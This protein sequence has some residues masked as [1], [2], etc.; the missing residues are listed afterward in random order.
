MESRSQQ[1]LRPGTDLR[2]SLPT[3]L[4]IHV[5]CWLST[6]SDVFNLAA[7]C[8]RHQQI[9]TDNA[10]FIY[11]HVAPRT[12]ECRCH[13]RDLLADRGGAAAD[14]PVLSV[15]DV[16]RLV[17]N[18][19]IVEKSIAQFNKNIVCH[20]RSKLYIP[21]VDVC[22]YLTGEQTTIASTDRRGARRS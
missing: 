13:A 14:S 2:M 17:R 16:R 18:S 9:W 8:R 20:V 21:C 7:T 1:Q 15:R 22:I 3:E 6:F 10:T 5:F 12:I 11:N 19:R 4:V